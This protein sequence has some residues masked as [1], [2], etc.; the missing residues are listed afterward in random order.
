MRRVLAGKGCKV[1]L[2]IGVTL[3][4]A[5]HCWVQLGS[6]VLTDPLDV[7]APYKPILIV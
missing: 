1:R 3:P 2:I 5:A 7:V 6:T 4:F